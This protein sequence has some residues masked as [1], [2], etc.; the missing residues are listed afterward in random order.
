MRANIDKETK[1]ILNERVCTKLLETPDISVRAGP[2]N[3]RMCSNNNESNENQETR[4]ATKRSPASPA[5]IKT[6]KKEKK[7]NKQERRNNLRKNMKE[8]PE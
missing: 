5:P 6:I 2:K 4:E 8:L 3:R 1:G 7:A